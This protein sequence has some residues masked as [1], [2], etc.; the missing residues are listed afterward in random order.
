MKLY[1]FLCFLVMLMFEIIVLY[2]LDVSLSG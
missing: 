2:L 1:F